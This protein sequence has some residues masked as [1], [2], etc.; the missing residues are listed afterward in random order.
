MDRNGFRESPPLYVR[1]LADPERMLD[2]YDVAAQEI[3]NL[4]RSEG[5]YPG[6][7]PGELGWPP[8]RSASG[9]IDLPGLEHRARLVAAIYDGVPALRDLR[10]AD[11]YRQFAT[12]TPPY[13]QATRIYLQLERQFVERG[14]GSTE[15][16]LVLYRSLYLDAL[17]KE[18]PFVPD[19]GEAALERARLTRAPLAHAQASAGLL[20]P[21]VEASDDPRWSARYT[22]NLEGARGEGSLRDLLHGIA[23]RTLD[24]IAAGELLATRFNLYN[25]LAW[26]GSSAW[27][28]INDAELLLYRLSQ[29]G[30][31]RGDR[32][33]RL[34][35]LHA[36]G[37]EASILKA[38]AMLIE[39]FQAHREDPATLRPA[40]YWYGHQ[41]SYLTRDMIDFTIRLIGR[42]NRLVERARRL[43]PAG[44]NEW[45]RELEVP[46]L[47]TG[48]IRGR[49]LEYPHVG[50]SVEL[51]PWRRAARLAR[52][53]V[54]SWRQG[55]RK[56]DLA[57]AR[58]AEDERL[59]LTWRHNLD[60]GRSTL[61]NFGI[62][63]RVR[64][65]PDFHSIARE[66][67]LGSGKRKTLFLPTH[68]SVLDH[69]IMYQALQ[70]PE[71]RAAMG[72]E[73]PVPCSM[74]A[75]AGLAMAGV[76]I[77]PWSLTMFG[78]SAETFDRLLEEVDGYVIADR[79]VD[80]RNT[81]NA[82][83][84]FAKILAKRPGVLYPALTTSAFPTQSLPLQ[85]ALFAILPQ[86]VVLIPVALRGSHSLWPKCPR[87][88]LRISPGL[89]EVMI[90]PP[91]LG[92]MT[93]LPRR[94]SMRIQ[95]EAAALFQA[96]HITNLLNPEPSAP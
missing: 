65:D 39:F 36:A 27:K 33:D 54:P 24:Y 92:E 77:G 86:D 52:W 11:A 23:E 47:L 45:L 75:R 59:E 17:A 58:L 56:L 44:E 34:D 80:A 12:L 32:R 1:L 94:R 16:F 72:W 50:R 88:N 28:V 84:R 64:I 73:R 89:V 46:P 61:A 5:Y 55:R 68:Q 4:G 53:V 6:W 21:R 96:V 13:R 2:L 82:I 67:D 91:M 15:D 83:Q 18:D 79:S 22:T 20:P 43:V 30:G 42:A 49:F 62:E 35:R 8:S 93:L 95:L 26:F 66:L 7:D 85:H 9:P 37:L 38:K 10:L 29:S 40:S 48:R 25:N 3:I 60:W 74:F 71:L 51:P 90:A 14:A 19:A 76:R 78:I 57:R 69:P 63:V 81:R 31:D 70:S 41:Y 87:G